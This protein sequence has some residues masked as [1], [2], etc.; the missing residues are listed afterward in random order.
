VKCTNSN[1]SSDFEI[2]IMAHLKIAMKANP[3]LVL[4][5]LLLA[6]YLEQT[7]LLPNITKTF[8]ESDKFSEAEVIELTLYDGRI[9]R[10]NGIVKFLAEVSNDGSQ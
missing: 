6:A 8:Q 3:A 4:P 5:S 7:E 2:S 10:G 1:L 9:L